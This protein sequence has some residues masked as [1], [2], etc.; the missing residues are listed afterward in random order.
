[1]ST[2]DTLPE[3]LLET[4]SRFVEE[5]AGLHFPR[6]RWRDLER[7]L[8]AVAGELGFASAAKCALALLSPHAKQ[9]HIA[10]LLAR[11]TVGETYFF[12]E[13][14][15]F[16]TLERKVLPELILAR[17]A[18]GRRLRIWS[19]GCCTGEEAYS[20][21][22]VLSRVLPDLEEWEIT[23]LGTDIN[24][25]FLKKAAAGIYSQ[26]SFRGVPEEMKTLYFRPVGEGRLEI[27]PRIRRMVTFSCVN[28]VEDAFPAL[29]TNTNAMDVIFCRNVLMYFSRE[30]AA[31]VA[32]RLHRSLLS[33]GWLFCAG[34][35]G[36]RDVFSVFTPAN[37]P[38]IVAYRKS[39]PTPG[40]QVRTPAIL[41]PAPEPPHT[42]A[43]P[44]V[45]AQQS[46]QPAELAR[47]FA[48]EGRFAD[49]LATCDRAIASEKMEPAHHY[50]RGLILQEQGARAQAAAALRRAL[51]LDHTFVPAHFALGNLMRH[52]G[53]HRDAGRCFRNAS[54]LL[55][56]YAS[57]TV[58]PDCDGMTA[59]RLRAI[60]DAI[61]EAHA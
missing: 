29:L 48:D 46:A 56:D 6:E 57:D 43:A 22:I 52:E 51:Y 8:R 39:Q 37:A 4:F 50:L 11:L 19:A 32:A 16:E 60:I 1:M 41:R 36:V 18:T 27:L 44:A 40:A 23:I 54:G 15:A 25:Q 45:A 61:Q 31:N 7:G 49:A 13:V 12:R 9:D 14:K 21:A 58:L 3:P 47:E 5:R 28:L 24:A 17:R 38:G 20:I 34:S 10:L 33:D 55:R 42:A 53:R 35:E 26:W 2:G 59:G 30:Q